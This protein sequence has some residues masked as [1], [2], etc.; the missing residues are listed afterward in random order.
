MR[1][2]VLLV[3]LV[4]AAMLPGLAQGFGYECSP[5]GTWYGGGSGPAKY[6][7]TITQT[8]FGHY[9][10]SYDEGFTPAVPK[11]SEYSGELVRVGFNTYV[12]RAIALANM[13]S[14]PPNA[15]GIPPQIW[16]I[17]ETGRLT[18]CNTMEFDIDFFGVYQW[19]RIPFVDQPD[20][21]KLPVEGVIHETY[22]RM[23]RKCAVCPSTQ[24]E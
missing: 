3:A 23:A 5:A 13:S 24:E 12:G 11:L 20:A 9:T 7:L 15:G 14:A 19:G 1:R 17:R 22:T 4:L 16:A 21:S 18:D 6:L 8:Y 2:T 10:Y